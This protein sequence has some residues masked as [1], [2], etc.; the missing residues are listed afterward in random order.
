MDKYHA[1]TLYATL[2]GA[3]RDIRIP[4]MYSLIMSPDQIQL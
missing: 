1:R 3:Y 2:R 4:S